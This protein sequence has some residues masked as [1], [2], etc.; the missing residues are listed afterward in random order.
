MLLV[1]FKLY[2]FTEIIYDSVNTD[3]NKAA[4]FCTFQLF[5]KFALFAPC[6]GRHNLY[7]CPLGHRHNTVNDIVYC[8]TGYL[9]STYGTMRNSYSCVE[10]PKIVIYFGNCSYS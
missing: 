1:F 8:L 7:F 10:Q 9:P 2:P 3:T 6:N 5:Y 4:L